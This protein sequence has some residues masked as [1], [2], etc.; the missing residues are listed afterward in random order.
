M[1]NL[2][3]SGAIQKYWTR[4]VYL[5]SQ[6]SGVSIQEQKRAEVRKV[7]RMRCSGQAVLPFAFYVLDLG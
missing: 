2:L 5:R 6:H 3:A 4:Q 7:Y 1:N